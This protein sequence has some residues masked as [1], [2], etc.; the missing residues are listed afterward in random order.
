M[1]FM[2]SI[3][4]FLQKTKLFEKAIRARNVKTISAKAG[5]L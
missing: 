1:A 3:K 2:V 4:G 5:T